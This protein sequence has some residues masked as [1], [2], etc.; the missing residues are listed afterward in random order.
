MKLKDKKKLEN[1]H[2]DYYITVECEHCNT[3][4]DLEDDNI[5]CSDDFDEYFCSTECYYDY[6]SCYESDGIKK[7]I[8]QQINRKDGFE[9][10]ADVDYTIE[11]KGE[12]LEDEYFD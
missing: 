6:F 8:F 10:E 9:F 7:R 12:D 2:E 5:Y 1:H 11:W 4:I 3:S